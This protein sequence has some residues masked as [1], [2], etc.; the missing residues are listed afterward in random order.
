MAAMPAS[1]DVQCDPHQPR[2]KSLRVAE[3]IKVEQRLQDGFLARVFCPIIPPKRSV[4][5][6]PEERLMTRNDF[7]EGS[8]ITATRGLDQFSVRFVSIHWPG[9][10]S[11]PQ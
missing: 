7:G 5:Y 4:T 11:S 6:G 1:A 8:S 3:V 10:P 2:T 9:T